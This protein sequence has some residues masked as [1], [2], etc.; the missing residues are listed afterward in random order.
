L[1]DRRYSKK[2]KKEQKKKITDQ[3]IE[4]M[5]NCYICFKKAVNP[6]MCP[7]CSKFSCQGCIQRWIVEQKRQCP[8]CRQPLEVDQLVNCRFLSDIQNVSE[9]RE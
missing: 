1:A 8:H 5:F 7:H 3:S 6:K 4:E 2:K 9:T